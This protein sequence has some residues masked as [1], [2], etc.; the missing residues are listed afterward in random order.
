MIEDEKEQE[1]PQHISEIVEELKPQ[2]SHFARF[3]NNLS[4]EHLETFLQKD[5]INQQR[6]L[7]DLLDNNSQLEQLLRTIIDVDINA[8][9]Y[10]QKP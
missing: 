3:Y 10:N 5:K 1:Q 2:L 4:L 8:K 7:S 6:I 9:T